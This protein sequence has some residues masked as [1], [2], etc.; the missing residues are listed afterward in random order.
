MQPAS[1]RSSTSGPLWVLLGVFCSIAVLWHLAVLLAAVITSSPARPGLQASL[2]AMIRS[3]L[4]PLSGYGRSGLPPGW[5]VW[6]L[7]LAMLALVGSG[8]WWWR[9]RRHGRG[10]R[11]GV[12]TR[13][14]LGPYLS[15]RAAR[16]GAAR[17]RPRMLGRDS[18]PIEEVAVPIGRAED[19]GMP[20]YA[21]LEDSFAVV[22][23]P[24]SFKTSAVIVHAVR[25]AP[26]PCVAVSTK[27]DLLGPT[28]LARARKGRVRVF[29]LT[30][31]INWPHGLQWSPVAGC[32]D[33]SAA[34]A[35]AE[36]FVAAM[37]RPNVSTTSNADFFDK[38]ATIV[39]RCLLHAAALAGSDWREVVEWSHRIDS[40]TLPAKEILATHPGAAPLFALE[41][42]TATRGNPN[43]GPLDSTQKTLGGFLSP[44]AWPRLLHALTPAPGEGLDIEAFLNSSDTVYIMTGDGESAAPLV[45]AFMN[46]VIRVA[47]RRSQRLVPARLD[48]PLRLVIDE[49]GQC[50][51]PDLPGVMSDSGGRG[52]T[53]LFGSQGLGQARKRWGEAGANEV[54]GSA[55]AKVIMGGTS[56][57]DFL[58]QMSQL[59]DE[60][61][62]ASESMT[63]TIDG[64]QSMTSGYRTRRVI[65]P[66][67]IRQL[68]PGHA[69]LL[70]RQAP[71]VITRFLPYWESDWADEARASQ[72]RV[73]AII[74]GVESEDMA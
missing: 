7:F 46:E 36:G 13:R 10:R 5:L 61:E 55:T 44:Y 15:E 22:G 67:E 69:L 39:L 8:L 53:V 26:G 56:E 3:P 42:E 12:G 54:F 17:T 37:P 43:E 21:A 32:D 29:D 63:T 24:R 68:A 6:P 1:P 50:P 66:A 28:Y 9:L 14:Q 47:R 11:E 74:S 19:T 49:V 60:V 40:P 59:G 72:E 73:A 30:N 45:A 35:R 38:Q 33:P 25:Q 70:Y 2:T 57:P 16:A 31:V 4:N 62:V 41:L 64:T 65:R 51:L 52:I 20:L 34:L 71:A 58:E 27:S 23:G 48:P 18:A